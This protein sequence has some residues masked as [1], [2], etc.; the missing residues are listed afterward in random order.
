M[1]PNTP[2]YA[3]GVDNTIM[4]GRHFYSTAAIFDSCMGII[5]TSILGMHITNQRHQES[6]TY[7][8]RLMTMWVDHFRAELPRFGKCDN[9]RSIID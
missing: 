7:L 6:R 2:H 8:R 1:R 5:H 4:L 3:M 9:S